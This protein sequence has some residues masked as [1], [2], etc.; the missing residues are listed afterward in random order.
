MNKVSIKSLVM[1]LLFNFL[2]TCIR[3]SNQGLNNYLGNRRIPV[4]TT[5]LESTE[6]SYVPENPENQDFYEQYYNTLIQNQ[7]AY[8]PSNLVP[9]ISLPRQ[10]DLFNE[11]N[12]SNGNNGNNGNNVNRSNTSLEDLLEE[13]ENISEESATS[14]GRLLN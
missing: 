9:P 13:E 7:D 12:G 1:F 10:T 6:N 14:L 5:D 11:S 3:R 2:V 8:V 4:T